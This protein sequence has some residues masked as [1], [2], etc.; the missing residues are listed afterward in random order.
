MIVDVMN[1]LYKR[2]VD[3]FCLATSDSDFMGLAMCSRKYNLTL[4]NAGEKKTP[5]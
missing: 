5:D 4:I 2:K 3:C 1:I